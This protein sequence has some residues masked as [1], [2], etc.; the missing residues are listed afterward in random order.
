MEEV[1]EGTAPAGFALNMSAI[2]IVEDDRRMFFIRS[3]VW[4]SGFSRSRIFD[5]GDLSKIEPAD[6]VIELTDRGRVLQSI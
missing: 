1:R 5:Q 3:L 2:A 4:T 6:S